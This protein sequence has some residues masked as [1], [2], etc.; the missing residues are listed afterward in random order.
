MKKL[1]G[2]FIAVT[3][4]ATIVHAQT[5]WI[6]Y[7]GDDRISVKFPSEPKEAMPGTVI[8][9]VKDSTIA[10]VFTIV[11]FAQV[12]HIDSTALAP[13]KATPE[14]AAQLKT[15]IKQGL[16]GV[17]LSDF[18]IGTWKGF[19]SYTSSGVDAQQKQYD[20]FMFI[21]GSKLYSLSTIRKQNVSTEN[22]DVYF[23]SIIL[24]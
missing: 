5:G 1:L 9:T 8:S 11:D 12:A 3:L 16:P 24:K 23:S 22:R 6:A 19:T 14:F 4:S 2:L 10:Y 20:I 17:D 7:K 18:K 13:I 21:I 15:G